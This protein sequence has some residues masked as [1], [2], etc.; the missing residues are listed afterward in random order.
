M[1]TFV[2]MIICNVMLRR[3]LHNRNFTCDMVHCNTTTWVG[4]TYNEVTASIEVMPNIVLCS[5]RARE[6][7]K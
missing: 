6:K 5:T 1:V 2:A 3:I 7:G 4:D